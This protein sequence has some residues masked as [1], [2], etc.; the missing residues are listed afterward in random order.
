[1][2]NTKATT[3]SSPPT[4]LPTRARLLPIAVGAACALGAL[5]ALPSEARAEPRA[6]ELVLGVALERNDGDN[7]GNTRAGS[8]FDVLVGARAS[9]K[10]WMPQVELS[11]GFHDFGGPLDAEVSRAMIGAR[12]GLDWFIRPSLFNHIGVERLRMDGQLGNGRTTGTYFAGETGLALDVRVLPQVDVGLQGSYNW[13]PFTDS[14]DWWQGGAH[15]TF[16]TNL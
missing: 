15:V 7:V 14:F 13:G 8:G 12:F 5:L 9:G 11:L 1:M 6:R 16:V 4:R 10:L 3:P 2:N